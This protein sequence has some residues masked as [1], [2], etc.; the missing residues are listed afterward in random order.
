MSEFRSLIGQCVS[1]G[2]GCERSVD[3]CRGESASPGEL[4]LIYRVL[5]PT[6]C[7]CLLVWVLC[8]SYVPLSAESLN[9]TGVPRFTESGRCVTRGVSV[10][11]VSVAL[12]FATIS[13][14]I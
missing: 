14:L 1:R 6:M 8:V 12:S 5:S 10:V 13:L 3:D 4:S 7:P 9:E 11:F 2:T